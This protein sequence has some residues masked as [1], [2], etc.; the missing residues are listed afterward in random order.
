MFGST[1]QKLNR[2]MKK[3]EKEKVNFKNLLKKY[4]INIKSVKTIFKSYKIII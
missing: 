2:K 3:A 1:E 4:K